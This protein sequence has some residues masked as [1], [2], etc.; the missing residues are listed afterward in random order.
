MT[1]AKCIQVRPTGWEG[2]QEMD[3]FPLS[4]MDHTMPK[5]YVQIAEV[6]ELKD[7]SEENKATIV[8]NLV[9]GLE[10]SLAQYPIMTGGLKMDP[11]T[12]RMWVAKKQD[13]SVG[14][15]VNVRD[16]PT[17]Q[18][19]NQKD[20]PA[21]ML[22]GHEIL[23]KS[24][25]EKQLF[26]PLGDNADEDLSISAFQVNFI[27]GGVILASAIHHNCSDGPG[28][29]GF[30][31]TWAENAAA[32]SKGEEF[33]PIDK[34]ALDRS[35]LSAAQ[36]P[37]QKRWQELNE[38]L[39][40]EYP[41]LKDAGGPPPAP[42]ADFK[43]PE[44]DIVMW[45]FAKSK[46]DQL[47]ATA[48]QSVDGTEGSWVS[49]YDAI[50]ASMWKA[51]TKA[52]IELLQPNLDQEVILAHAVNTR[53]KLDPPLPERFMGNAVAL[54]RTKPTKISDL[55]A[56]PIPEVARK[57][58]DSINS[59]TPQYVGEL[60]EWIAGLKDKR[61]IS[62]NMNSFL[63]MDLAGT[64]W[65]AMQCYQKHDFGF[66]L[67]KAIRFPCPAFEGYCFI[68]PSRAAVKEDAD[69]EGFEVCVCLEKGCQQR[70]MK[71]EELLAYAQPRGI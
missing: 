61:W 64:S 63:G 15:Y 69:D 7:E 54:P 50:M 4:D 60:P 25:T 21:A 55:V 6:F 41:I 59:I 57:V 8:A 56:A 24:V 34:T 18:E 5:I 46:V 10:F 36:V 38:K 19:L 2:G 40:L 29:D 17:Y 14:L 71:D 67:T 9:K 31:T 27:P 20:F 65:Q 16:T 68:Y 13:S 45:H 43:M 28:C 52:K 35:R 11:E 47:K 58:R 70:L 23:P 26:S 66:G 49:T 30:L 32:A 3:L 62:I 22:K 37:D 33:K 44:L 39:S 53:F 51:I 12:G 48:N 1:E 42:P